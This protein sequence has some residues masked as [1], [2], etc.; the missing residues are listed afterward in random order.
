MY[1]AVEMTRDV[2]FDAI[3]MTGLVVGEADSFAAE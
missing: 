2:F 1:A 3:E